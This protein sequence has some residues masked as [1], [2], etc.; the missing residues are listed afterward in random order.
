MNNGIFKFQ[1]GAFECFSIF[2]GYY[3]GGQAEN[4]FS[5][6]PGNLLD[7]AL[8][9]HNL[10]HINIHLPCTCLF[11]DTGREKILVDTGYGIYS[12]ENPLA[13]NS[14]RLLKNLSVLGI[15]PEQIDLVILTHCDGDHIGGTINEKGE[16]RFKNARYVITKKEW[17]YW[18]NQLR[19]NLLSTEESQFIS[20]YL[21]SIEKRVELISDKSEI[22]PGI[23]SAVFPG[24]SAGHLALEIFSKNKKMVY[25]SDIVCH[26]IHLEY[27]DWKMSFEYDPDQA[28]MSRNKIFT[29]ITNEDSLVFGFH[30][31]FP[32]LGRI[33]KKE[34]KYSWYPYE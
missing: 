10:S 26:L 12:N 19:N 8:K 24:H 13:P 4:L 28:V 17:S 34:S 2:D 21:F 6:A 3:E 25:I 22:V 16:P 33:K 7:A 18:K 9:K 29:K 30:L 31:P 27:P 32:A 1:I 20:K 11:I 14:G 5:N 23:T 15:S